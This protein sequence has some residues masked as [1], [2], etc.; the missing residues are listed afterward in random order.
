MPTLNKSELNSPL[1]VPAANTGS[2]NLGL[3]IRSLHGPPDHHQHTQGHATP[4][5]P[6]RPRKYLLTIPIGVCTPRPARNFRCT[7]VRTEQMTTRTNNRW[8]NRWRR[9]TDSRRVVTSEAKLVSRRTA[10]EGTTCPLSQRF[11]APW[12]LYF[13]VPTGPIGHFAW[14]YRNKTSTTST[15]T[16][17]YAKAFP[18]SV[19]IARF[20]GPLWT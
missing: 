14:A 13:V 4:K 12:G 9:V 15:T 19:P 20:S 6:T 17:Q 3:N 16:A 10:L 1:E 2:W 11:Y 5:T 8:L 18:E 7:A